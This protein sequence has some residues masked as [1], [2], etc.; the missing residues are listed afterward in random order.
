VRVTKRAFG[1]IRAVAVFVAVSLVLGVLIGCGNPKTTATVSPT[2]RAS[3]DPFVGTWYSASETDVYLTITK[4]GDAYI[5]N[6]A[7]ENGLKVRVLFARHGDQ[8]VSRVQPPRSVGYAVAVFSPA[9]K[10]LYF[11][12]FGVNAKLTRVSYSKVPPPWST[13]SP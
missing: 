10:L 11:S 9:S 4:H 12:P 3:H 5:A 2:P 6:A 1:R 8:L 13:A 7:Y